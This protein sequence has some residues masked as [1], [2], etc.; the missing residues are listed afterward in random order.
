MLPY[1]FVGSKIYMN[2]LHFDGMA[3]SSKLEFPDLFLTL[4]YTPTWPEIT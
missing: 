4:T 3:I 2:Q 1:T